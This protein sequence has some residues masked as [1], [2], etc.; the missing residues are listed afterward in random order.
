MRLQR[1]ERNSFQAGEESVARRELQ[2]PGDGVW[3]N[4]AWYPRRSGGHDTIGR[5][6]N[7]NGF[8]GGCP[9][10]F[11]RPQI[12]V[13]GRFGLLLVTGAGQEAEV[14]KQ[15]QAFQ[16]AFYPIDGR[17]GS[18]GAGDAASGGFIQQTF[19]PGKNL[20]LFN[21]FIVMGAALGINGLPIQRAPDPFFQGGAGVENAVIGSHDE[22]IFLE[23][24]SLT[25]S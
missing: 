9:Q 5:I 6:F 15:L 23:A 4:N 20:V 17:T 19:Y 16:V 22:G 3:N 25:V 11:Q 24:E 14:M 1:F 7:R 13:G 8:R 18:D 21:Q 2:S 10:M 12:D